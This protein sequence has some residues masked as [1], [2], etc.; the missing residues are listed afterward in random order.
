M[1]I[2]E[3]AQQALRDIGK[4][5]HLRQIHL[6]IVE[7]GYFHFGALNPVAALG[8]QID[9]HAKGVLISKPAAPV[10]FYRDRPATYGLLEWLDTAQNDDVALDAEIQQSAELEELDTS[11]FLEQE[12]Q[13]WLF[14]NWEKTRLTALQFGPLELFAPDEQRPKFGKYNTGIVGEVD[15]LFRTELGDILICELKRNSTD[16]TVGQLCRYWGWAS[17]TIGKGK[18]VYGLVLAREIGD[19]LRLAIKATNENISYREL[20]LDVTL[21]P[22]MR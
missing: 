3:A 6:H 13:R 15:L 2:Y 22:S 11:L 4:P 7:R 14:K 18:R 9:R 10:V 21:G 17:E 20:V 16:Q 1:H 8:V 5:S 19:S 12:L